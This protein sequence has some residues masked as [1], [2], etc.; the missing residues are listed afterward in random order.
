MLKF[1]GTPCL[2]NR[3]R[4]NWTRSLH[5]PGLQFMGHNSLKHCDRGEA[6]ACDIHLRASRGNKCGM[7]LEQ[8]ARHRSLCWDIETD[9]GM[10]FNKKTD[11]K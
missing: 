7:F 5:P 10:G 6:L 2:A 1:D 11:Y 3:L 8:G 4:K 9:D